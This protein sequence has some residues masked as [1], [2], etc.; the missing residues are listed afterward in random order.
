MTEP[1]KEVN[2]STL[3]VSGG[4]LDAVIEVDAEA[5]TGPVWAKEGDSRVTPIGSF[6]RGTSLDELPQLINVLRGI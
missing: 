4:E 5:E 6:L 2:S 1:N 3:H